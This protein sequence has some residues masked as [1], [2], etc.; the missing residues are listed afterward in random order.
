MGKGMLAVEMKWK[1]NYVCFSWYFML[2]LVVLYDGDKLGTA[3]DRL[4]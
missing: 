1:E 2:S 4:R 3:N